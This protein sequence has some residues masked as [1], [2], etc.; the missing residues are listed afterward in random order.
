[1]SELSKRFFGR[2]D[3][4]LDKFQ[5]Q[6]IRSISE[7]G[8]DYRQIKK[9]YKIAADYDYLTSKLVDQGYSRNE[10]ADMS[11]PN[12]PNT[13]IGESQAEAAYRGGYDLD[14]ILWKNLE[15]ILKKYE[16]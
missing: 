16:Q 13:T 4:R 7:G 12:N 8:K 9:A 11:D 14:D 1:M 10:I 15:P 3:R 6:D 5:K 2:K